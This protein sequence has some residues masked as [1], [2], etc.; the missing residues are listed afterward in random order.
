[1]WTCS[2][3][4]G[5]S[6]MN[7]SPDLLIIQEKWN[8]AFPHL[9]EISILLYP[10]LFVSVLDWV[11]LGTRPH[12]FSTLRGLKILCVLWNKYTVI[13]AFFCQHILC[14]ITKRLHLNLH[15]TPHGYCFNLFSYKKL[16]GGDIGGGSSCCCYNNNWTRW[17]KLVIK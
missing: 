7:Q 2:Y 15:S 14:Q 16:G 13:V 3:W 8:F 12:F 17:V 1:M 4:R 5:T 9:C 10:D 6:W 11:N